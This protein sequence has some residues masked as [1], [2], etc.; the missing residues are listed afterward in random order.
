MRNIQITTQYTM[1]V[2]GMDVWHYARIKNSTRK[3]RKTRIQPE[4][5]NTHH[6][7]S[8]SGHSIPN[9]ARSRWTSRPKAPALP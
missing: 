7:K 4:T 1:R 5:R 6:T 3:T 9:N 2:N 8:I